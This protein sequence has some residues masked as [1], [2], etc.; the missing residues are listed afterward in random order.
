MLQPLQQIEWYGV[1]R[2]YKVSYRHSNSNTPLDAVTIEDH[3][4]NWFI[5]DHLEEFTLYEIIVQAYNDVGLSLPSPSATE[6]TREAIPSSGPKSV[7]ADARS[8]TTIVVRWN[9]VDAPH[10]N[11]IIEGYKVYFGALNVPFQYKKVPSNATFTTTLTEL[12][13]FTEYTIHVLAYTRVGD[14]SLSFPPVIIRTKEDGNSFIEIIHFWTHLQLR[15][16]NVHLELQSRIE[17]ISNVWNNN[18]YNFVNVI[19]LVNNFV[20][21]CC[22]VM[23]L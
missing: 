7:T 10:R 23:I 11:G 4:A 2:G 19:Q 21:F 22:N 1:P 16:T 18:S 5:L 9:E 8:S 20:I 6:R 14:G 13:K 3:N 12:K 15:S 17:F